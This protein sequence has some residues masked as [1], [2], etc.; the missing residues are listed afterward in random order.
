LSRFIAL[1]AEQGQLYL[2]SVNV[3]LNAVKLEKAILIPNVGLL[4]ASNAGDVG[5]RV[6]EALKDAGIASA[7]MVIS[8][9][10]E[11]VILKEV[12][13]PAGVSA[14]DEPALGRFQVA[15]ELADGGDVVIDYFALPTLDPDGQRRALAFAVRKEILAACR[16]ACQAAGLKLAAITPRPFGIAASL[17]RAIKDGAVTPPESATSSTAVLVRGDKWGELVILRAGHVAFTRSLTGQALNSEPALLGEI[18]RNLAVFAGQSNQPV[19]ALFVAEGESPGGGWSGRIQA[20]LTIPVQSFDPIAGVDADVSPEARG[21]FAGLSGLAYLRA[22]SS[23]L[24]I[25]FVEPRQPKV[26]TDPGKRLLGMVAA[27]AAVLLV[28]GLIAGR[29]IVSKRSEE[30]RILQVKKVDLEESIGKLEDVSKRVKGVKEWEDKGVNWLDE[31]YDLTARFPDPKYTEVVQ[32]I[33][34]PNET[35][36]IAAK[37]VAELELNIQTEAGK[38]VDDLAT[39]IVQDKHYSV[40]G[41]IS[42]GAVAGAGNRIN[43]NSKNQQ[44][45]L[46]VHLERRDPKEYVLQLNANGPTWRARNEELRANANVIDPAA[47]GG[48][49]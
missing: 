15:K 43:P 46:K 1:D 38:H 20:G 41:K 47:L 24:P 33:G 22:R 42:K 35:K 25:N 23:E 49:P 10:R 26:A 17:M 6:K 19:Q 13:Y 39:R 48:Q 34:R 12:K 45:S 14:A 27:A 30:L 32:M 44:F 21:C 31:L 40:G 9:G 7:P 3:K 37:Y 8:V 29:Y 18:R 36:G 28:V 5:L 2:A 11:R 16:T 4:T